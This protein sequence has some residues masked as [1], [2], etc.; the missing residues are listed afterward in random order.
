MFSDIFTARLTTSCHRLTLTWTANKENEKSGLIV[1]SFRCS[2]QGSPAYNSNSPGW[3][4]Q[5]C[6]SCAGG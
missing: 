6:A 1:S 4:K 2:G 3:K 5:H